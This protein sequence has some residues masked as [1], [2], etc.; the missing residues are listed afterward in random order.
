MFARSRTGLL[1]YW[2]TRYFIALTV[3]IT[4]AGFAAYSTIQLD[5]ERTQR[6]DML[7][8]AG[9]L[10]EYAAEHGGLLP[11][12]DRLG[13]FLEE[14]ALKYG[15][16]GR[17][18]VFVYDL[19]GA[20]IQQFPSAPSVDAGLLAG[21]L[22]HMPLE[23][24]YVFELPPQPGRSAHLAAVQLIGV[25]ESA[26]GY[27]LYVAPK[28]DQLWTIE[29]KQM[30]LT[31][32]AALLLAGWGIVYM[33]TRRLVKP[34]RELADAANQIV[35]GNYNV[36][37]SK[38]YKEKEIYELV[39]AF[40][41]MAERLDHLETLRAQRLA[42]VTHELKTPV[43]SISGFVQA[44]K[45]GV[46]SGEEAE[47]FLTMC[48]QESRRLEKMVDDLL[49][50]NSATA[51]PVT[52]DLQLWEL[53]TE[54]GS[55]LERWRRGQG[56]DHIRLTFE[57]VEREGEGGFWANTDAARL[58]QI[59]VNLLNNAREATPP[60]GTIR[61]LLDAEHGSFRIRIED[62][63]GGIP[64]E[65]QR[66]IFEPLYRGKTKKSSVRGLGIGLPLSRAIAQ[67]LGGDLLLA[68]SDPHG[69]TFALLLPAA[70]YTDAL[71]PVGG[72]QRSARKPIR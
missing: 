67:A 57:A 51:Q 16:T 5:A 34:V 18:I 60:E 24:P 40:K 38:D 28:I 19:G 52:I 1:R 37:L 41:K 50:Y 10:A 69:T 59:I 46:V 13:P 48:L 4:L 62:S 21:R 44:L 26:S 47:A 30:R 61:V 63:G 56:L 45:D 43:T 33:M 53:R 66:L 23:S 3:C 58:E 25:G 71:G 68:N 35:A 72:E 15:L 12:K 7:R 31:L 17:P 39:Y 14:E 11:D 49:D 2:S 54:I 55:I 6:V 27:M 22:R 64:P 8:L 20:V 36:Q 29:L 65:E 9:A 70:G 32:I 42:G